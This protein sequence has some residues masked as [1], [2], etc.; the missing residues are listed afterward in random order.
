MRKNLQVEKDLVSGDIFIF[1]IGR[2]SLWKKLEIKSI[3]GTI[4][5]PKVGFFVT[6]NI[7]IGGKLGFL[8]LLK[9]IFQVQTLKVL[10][11]L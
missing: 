8:L 6:E 2:I 1:W 10:Y 9:Q 5:T 7:A 4:V 11:Y 3:V